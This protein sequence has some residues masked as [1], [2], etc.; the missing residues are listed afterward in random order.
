MNKQEIQEKIKKEV[1][2][3]AQPKGYR[4]KE[5]LIRFYEEAKELG[6]LKVVSKCG[7]CGEDKHNINTFD[8]KVAWKTSFKNDSKEDVRKTLELPNFDYEVFEELSG[9]SKKMINSKVKGK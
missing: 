4:S 6:L 2:A 7:K 1:V 8:F 5:S 9:I 3:H